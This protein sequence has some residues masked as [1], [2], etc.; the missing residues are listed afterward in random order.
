MGTA[1]EVEAIMAACYG[2][3][4]WSLEQIEAD[5]AQPDTH[6]YFVGKEES[7]GFLSLLDL[8]EEAEITNIAVLPAYR[9]QGLGHELVDKA[10]Q[11]QGDLFLEVRESNVVA[12][13]LYQ[14][15]GFVDLAVRKNY[16]HDPVEDAVMMRREG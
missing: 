10:T 15:Y 11:F 8:G 16:Y 4:P 9:G 2:S 13:K 12:R 7:V 3:S 6:Y 1:K 5:M 14:E